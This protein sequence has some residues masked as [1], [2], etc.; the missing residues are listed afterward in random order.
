MKLKR[1]SLSSAVAHLVLVRYMLVRYLV[2]ILPLATLAAQN[3]LPLA[4]D[5]EALPTSIETVESGGYWSR[6]HHDG[7]YRLVIEVLGWDALYNR[8]MLQWIT[9]DPD[10][11]ATV[12]ER[13]VAIKEIASRWRISSQKFEQREKQTVIVIV[14]ERLEPPGKATFTITPAADY[15]YKITTSEK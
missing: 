15:T 7:T 12:V 11:Q 6:D 14:A 1:R 9:T 10:K 5:V 13:T 2:A 8:A 3:E 4:K